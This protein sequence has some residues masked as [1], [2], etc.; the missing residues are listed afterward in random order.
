VEAAVALDALYGRDLL[1]GCTRDCDLAAT[2]WL[3]VKQNRAGAA[4]PFAA[5]VLG[6]GEGEFLAEGGEEDAIGG[7][8]EAQMA[9]I[10]A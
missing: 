5:A 6:A 2:N 10:H 8:V 3:A 4:L 1:V 7:D 9:R